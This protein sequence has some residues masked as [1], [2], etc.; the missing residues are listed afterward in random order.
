MGTP[1]R[2]LLL[3]AALSSTAVAGG[4]F[5]VRV[6]LF[7]AAPYFSIRGY[8]EE[9]VFSAAGFALVGGTEFDSSGLYPYTALTYDADNLFLEVRW[10]TT[11]LTLLASIIW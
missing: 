11:Q 7:G 3:S 4:S 6:S 9:E 8:V 2:A 1:L 10:S 5:G